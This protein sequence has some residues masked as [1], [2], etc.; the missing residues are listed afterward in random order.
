M[1]AVLDKQIA[2]VTGASRGIGK[3][4]A[5]DLARHGATVVGTATTESGAASISDYLNALR[6]DAGR[7]VALNV[8]DAEASLA[9]RKST[10]LN[11][12]HE[13]KSRMPSSA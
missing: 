8:N 11:S 4:I 10:R 6:A 7:G 2:L 5:I 13:L 1:S 9:D 12:S 3:A